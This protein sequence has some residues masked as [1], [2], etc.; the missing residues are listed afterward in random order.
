MKWKSILGI[1]S[2]KRKTKL[3]NNWTKG[4]LKNKKAG[5]NT[6]QFIVSRWVSKV[7]IKY[8]GKIFN[9]R[10]LVVHEPRPNLFGSDW[11][12]RL[13][14]DLSA[15]CYQIQRTDV[16]Q[17]FSELFKPGALK[18]ATVKLYINQNIIPRFMKA[19]LVSSTI[20]DKVEAK[21]D[22]IVATLLSKVFFSPQNGLPLSS[23]FLKKNLFYT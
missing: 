1:V 9:F 10:V 17:D 6:G 7:T 8:Q 21:R 20:R 13:Q 19:K 5:W 3:T 14:I 23:Q 2:D 18:N 4:F 15:I 22:G 11:P 12:E 16:E